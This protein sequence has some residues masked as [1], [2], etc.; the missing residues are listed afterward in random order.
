MNE[1]VKNEIDKAC[2]YKQRQTLGNHNMKLKP[3]PEYRDSGIEWIGEIPEEWE[4]HKIKHL[5]ENFDG[6]R[7]PISSEK[8]EDGKIP[9]YGATGVLDYVKDFIF[10][11][12]LLLVGEDGAPFF[13]PFKDVAY[14]INGKSWVNNHAHVLRVIGNNLIKWL[15]YY[16]NIYD[17][18]A[19]IKGSTRDKLNQDQLSNMFVVKPSI[20]DQTAIAKFLHKKTAGIG[21]LIEKDKRLIELLK[22]KRIT[23]INHA[24]TKGLDPNANM[25][26]S[27]IE[28]IGKIPE[29]WKV[30]RLKFILDNKKNSIKTGPFGSQLTIDEMYDSEYKVYNQKNVIKKDEK[31]GENYVSSEKFK[32][33]IAFKTSPSDLLIT[34]RGTIG[35]TLRLSE[36]AE[37][38]IL[39]PCLMKINTNKEM[40][41]DRYVELI[42]EDSDLV[43]IQLQLQSCAT[44]IDVIYQ[45]NLKEINLFIPPINEQRTI[46]GYL[47]KQTLKIDK[48]IQKIQ[49]KIELLEEYKKSLIHNVVTGKIDV[50]EV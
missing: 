37:I 20:K 12:E 29:K 24:V 11:K 16:L 40:I 18:G 6:K 2:W 7:I 1:K 45:D 30:R 38:G 41:L 10:N 47:D 42:I 27:G 36:G 8:R 33:L 21:A 50:R 35:K 13:E 49:K 31:L 9:Y 28:W 34:T 17:Y 39:H 44:T 22:E 15:C 3:Y 4:I 26:D 46:I 23:L 25:K 43:R 32:E 14:I 48:T 5:T 19:V